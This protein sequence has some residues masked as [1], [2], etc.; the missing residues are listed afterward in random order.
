ML[1]ENLGSNG[2]GPATK[3]ERLLAGAS[4]STGDT[5]M[6]TGNENGG[7]HARFDFIRF[8]PSGDVAT[9]NEVNFA[10][11]T[12]A[13]EPSTDGQFTVSL[14][15]AAATDTVVSYSVDGSATA[16]ADYTALS[17][18]V[19][20]LAGETTATIDVSVLDDTDIE[21][22]EDVVVTLDAITSGDADVVVGALNIA[23]VTISDDDGVT[24]NE[25]NFTAAFPGSE[26]NIGGQFT[27]S[28][29]AA[30]ATDTVVSYGVGGTATANADYTALDGTITI[31]AGE[32][33]ATIDIDVLEDAVVEGPED[34]VVTLNAITSG[35]ANVV[36]GAVNIA[37][38]TINDDDQ[39]AS[40]ITIEA[41]DID[42]VTGYRIEN[43]GNASN[44]SMLSL[45]GVAP[46]EIGSA[47]FT[48]GDTPDELTG[49]YDIEIG[50]FDENDGTASFTL[51]LTDFNTGFTTE[52]GSVV[53]DAISSSAGATAGTK[54]TKLIASGISLGANDILTVNGF[55]EGSEHARLDFITL[56][57]VV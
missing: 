9:T 34:V 33:S 48:F 23:T 20:I 32:T 27:L 2:A 50:T 8:E 41:E 39:L 1:D 53:L 52:I 43:N 31:L 26:P 13:S 51:E 25:V 36:I 10:V 38:A 28:L 29:T 3:V 12:P 19:T 49:N 35:D 17:G 14:A 46:N 15:T 57:P 44:G 45:R 6:V 4:L 54:T 37:T 56:T 21:I 22:P 11:T 7:E 47:S 40:A 24:A 16:S 55:E 18:T 30:A 42:V 5:I